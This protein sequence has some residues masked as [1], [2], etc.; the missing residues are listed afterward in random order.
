MGLIG[1]VLLGTADVC[2]Y[3]EC[4][5]DSRKGWRKEQGSSRYGSLESFRRSGLYGDIEI[6]PDASSDACGKS[7]T[8]VWNLGY[9]RRYVVR[10][11]RGLS[12]FCVDSHYHGNRG[13]R[14]TTRGEMLSFDCLF[15]SQLRSRE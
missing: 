12:G 4:L 8:F 7:T 6:H 2:R 13:I 14:E 10:M 5:K 11:V 1:S 3:I 15:M 9:N